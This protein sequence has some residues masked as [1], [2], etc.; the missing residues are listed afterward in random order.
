[1][2]PSLIASFLVVAFFILAM[3]GI[4]FSAIFGMASIYAFFYP[5]VSPEDINIEEAGKTMFL[6]IILVV[7]L[8][9]GI[10]TGLYNRNLY[11]HDMI[12]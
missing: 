5:A 4:V 1:M 8:I 9:F 7:L 3:I 10:L 12:D 6:A 2:V 11:D